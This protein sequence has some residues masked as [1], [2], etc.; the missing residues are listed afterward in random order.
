[1]NKAIAVAVLG[2]LCACSSSKKQI[3]QPEPEKSSEVK[4]GPKRVPS[5][6]LLDVSFEF[7]SGTE[8]YL[9]RLKTEYKG[10]WETL[11]I[12][13]KGPPSRKVSDDPYL[14][15]VGI[16]A[17]PFDWEQKVLDLCPLDEILKGKKNDTGMFVISDG[18]CT[19]VFRGIGI[20][21]Q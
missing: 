20:D 19:D 3:P 15:K 16:V 10:R 8:N 18:S 5:E 14:E 17:G 6:N 21:L 9:L 4:K 2:F 11:E 12:K 7:Y 13:K 1:M